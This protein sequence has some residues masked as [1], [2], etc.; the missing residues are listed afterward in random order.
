MILMYSKSCIL[1][2]LNFLWSLNS[3]LQINR[4]GAAY[5]LPICQL[6]FKRKDINNNTLYKDQIYPRV[7]SFDTFYS[8]SLSPKQE[9]RNK[10]G[11]T[12]FICVK[13]LFNKSL[14]VS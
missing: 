5:K 12:E 9:V 2:Q 13:I 3:N 6:W 8:S 4:L 1:L 14:N 11:I 10:K 7:I